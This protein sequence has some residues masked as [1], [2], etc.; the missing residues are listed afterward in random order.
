MGTE[1]SERSLFVKGFCFWRAENYLNGPPCTDP[2]KITA[3][4]PA[5]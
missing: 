5:W 2:K 3:G 1:Y 4:V